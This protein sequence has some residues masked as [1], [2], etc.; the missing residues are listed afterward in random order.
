M[1]D[2]VKV[3]IHLDNLSHNYNL[4][5]KIHHQKR[6]MAVLKADAYG[7]GA[8]ESAKHLEKSGCDF[9]A[10]TDLIEAIEL[11]EAGIQSDILMFGKT[12]PNNIE[13]IKK[14]NLTQTVDSYEYAKTLNACEIEIKTHIVI[15]TGMSRFGIYCH[16]E[17]D[18]LKAT[19]EFIDILSL[20]Y[21][22]NQGVYTHFAAAD[23]DQ[24]SFTKDQYDIFIE[25]IKAVEFKGFN[26]GLKHCSNSAGLLKYGDRQLDMVRTGIAMYGYPPIKSEL[27]FLPVME[28]FAKVISIRDIEIGDG[29]S[30][31]LTYAAKKPM[32]IASIAIGYADGYNRLFSNQDYFVY[33][34]TKLNVLGRVCMGVTM[35]D[36]T[37]VDISVGDFVEVFGQNKSLDKMAK[38]ID[39]ITYELLTNMSKK[40]VVFEYKKA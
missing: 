14:Y 28:V 15:D 40:R 26:L 27:N 11:R 6:V 23:E 13:N 22:K 4:L 19:D 2:R 16:Q 39:T 33:N 32:R 12:S 36:V 24:E 35:V 1:I 18:L 21:L 34:K 10:V 38:K 29:V 25:L 31:G 30:Y 17:K 20:T 5:N 8:I 7:H 37:G 3:L 9:F